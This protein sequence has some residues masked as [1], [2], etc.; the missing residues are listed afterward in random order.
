[1]IKQLEEIEYPRYKLIS[2]FALFSHKMTEN[3][4]V[5]KVWLQNY[6]VVQVLQECMSEDSYFYVDEKEFINKKDAES[7]YNELSDA[8]NKYWT[9]IDKTFNIGHMKRTYPKYRK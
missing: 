1:M 2:R 7:Y 9:R 6:Y 5:Y 8:I 4:K 3:N